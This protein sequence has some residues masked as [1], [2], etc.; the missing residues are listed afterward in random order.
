MLDRPKDHDG[1][2]A[3]MIDR[4]SSE[5]ASPARVGSPVRLARRAS[6]LPHDQMEFTN[7]LLE[8]LAGMAVRS[9]RR[10]ADLGVSLRRAGLDPDPERV[11]FALQDLLDDGCVGGMVELSDGGM[12]LTVT[13]TG[14]DRLAGTSRR[15][16]L[17]D[18]TGR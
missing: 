11:A 17:H 2:Y 10:Q 9:P 12:L 15:H 3:D 7:A 1:A 16:V 6:A 4:T 8:A 18:L 14:I 5:G 13:T